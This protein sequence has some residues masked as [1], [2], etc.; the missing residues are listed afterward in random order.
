MT[1]S[2]GVDPGASGAIAILT[3]FGLI[4]CID[5]PHHC[6]YA[7]LINIPCIKSGF[8]INCH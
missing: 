5:M 2:I 3:D 1:I 4:E 7:H 8:T 6:S